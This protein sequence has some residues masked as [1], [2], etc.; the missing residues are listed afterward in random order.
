MATHSGKKR[1]RTNSSP[2]SV[3]GR[4][5]SG[6]SDRR[7]PLPPTRRATRDIA[8][9]GARKSKQAPSKPLPEKPN[10]V[11][12]GPRRERQPHGSVRWGIAGGD[13]LRGQRCCV[14][15]GIGDGDGDPTAGWK[16]DGARVRC[17]ACDGEYHPGCLDPHRPYVPKRAKGEE[18]G[19]VCGVCDERA[20]Y[21]PSGGP[22]PGHPES[23]PSSGAEAGPTSAATSL[24]PQRQRPQQHQQHQQPRAVASHARFV[25]VMSSALTRLA[26]LSDSEGPRGGSETAS[27]TGTIVEAAVVAAARRASKVSGRRSQKRED[28]VSMSDGL[29]AWALQSVGGTGEE[30]KPR[31]NLD[32]RN[33]DGNI[34]TSRKADRGRT[35]S[36]GSILRVSSV[37]PVAGGRQCEA[38]VR[39]RKAGDQLP[40]AESEGSLGDVEGKG[41]GDD[42]S[43]MAG[44]CASDGGSAGD[45]SGHAWRSASSLPS[46]GPRAKKQEGMARS[47]GEASLESFGDVDVDGGGSEYETEGE[48]NPEE[49]K[50]ESDERKE[51]GFWDVD[52]NTRFLQV[53]VYGDG[54]RG[55]VKGRG[56]T[57]RRRKR[58]RER[59]Q[60]HPI[61]GPTSP[62]VPV[63]NV[64]RGLHGSPVASVF[65]LL[66]P[67]FYAR[68]ARARASSRTR[69]KSHSL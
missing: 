32:G 67:C 42:N 54:S 58:E 49:G 46:L 35:E 63:S 60:R 14:A 34:R 36:G 48:A 62:S 61:A 68:R 15:C 56:A 11:L 8:L 52:E 27:A 33:G 43:G 64:L 5:D 21:S 22:V 31:G 12:K 30:G 26:G 6:K 1:R 25:D 37:S 38:N 66:R 45:G 4:G 50:S 47:H 39:R 53:R 2:G 3:A 65:L 57:K 20:L 29:L 44:E 18:E 13:L 23:R 59:G 7:A 40:E 16:A 55:R 24:T 51:P 41:S 19:W 10:G 28:I 69:H 17:A 9:A